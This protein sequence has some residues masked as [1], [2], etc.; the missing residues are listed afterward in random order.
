MLC[1]VEGYDRFSIHGP[2]GLC[3]DPSR[4]QSSM[5]LFTRY[6]FFSVVCGRT[7]KGSGAVDPDLVIVRSRDRQHLER[8][9]ERFPHQ[10]W[11]L[12]VHESAGT[13]YAYRIFV[14]KKTWAKLSAVLASEINYDDFKAEAGGVHHQCL[15]RVDVLHRI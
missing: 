5:W 1:G 12:K 10:F 4:G 9:K 8:L 2:D 11:R 14:E 6:G 3:S 13:D 7:N 15:G